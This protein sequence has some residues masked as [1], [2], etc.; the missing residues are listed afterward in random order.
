MVDAVYNKTRLPII[1]IGGISCA[2]DV[3]EFMLCGATAIQIGTALFIEPDLPVKI[4]SGLEKYLKN[5]GL[6]SILDL[7][8]KVRKY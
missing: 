5:R 1:G 6:N 3:I 2:E 8:G 7:K 4:Q